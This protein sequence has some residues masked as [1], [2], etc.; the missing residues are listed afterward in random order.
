[1]HAAPYAAAAGGAA[2]RDFAGLPA[3]RKAAPGAPPPF[4]F[5][6][7]IDFD[8]STHRFRFFSIFHLLRPTFL[9]PELC[10]FHAPVSHSLHPT[11]LSSTICRALCPI[12]SS[13]HD[14]S[15]IRSIL[16]PHPPSAGEGGG[17]GRLGILPLCLSLTLLAHLCGLSLSASLPFSYS[18]FPSLC[19]SLT[20][21]HLCAF[22]SPSL[23]VS[24]PFSYPPCQSLL[25]QSPPS[26]PFSLQPIAAFVPP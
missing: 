10:L 4:P 9:S 14:L 20:L 5:P 1:M 21:A 2:A 3:A 11:P 22:L 8:V 12:R 18:P 19:L 23:P 13:F 24:V 26:P 7:S 25:P 17:G 15:P 6:T 16:F